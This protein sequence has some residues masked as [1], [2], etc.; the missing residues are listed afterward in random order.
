MD[1]QTEILRINNIVA[2]ARQIIPSEQEPKLL[3]RFYNLDV[4]NRMRIEESA[5]MHMKQSVHIIMQAIKAND[6]QRV[7]VSYSGGKASQL[8]LH[9]ADEATFNTNVE[10]NILYNNTSLDFPDHIKYVR[11]YCNEH[12]PH[13]E[14]HEIH[15]K[16]GESFNTLAPALGFPTKKD[17]WCCS[18]LKIRPT[19]E[20]MESVQ[21]RAIQL[22]GNQKSENSQRYNYLYYAEDH[23]QKSEIPV[24]NPLLNWDD[25]E[26]WSYLHK[27]H[28]DTSPLY[29]KTV[30]W[31][32][33]YRHSHEIQYT[34]T[35]CYLCPLSETHTYP[36]WLIVKMH[37]PKLWAIM[38]KAAK[39][40]E[41]PEIK[42]P[43][44]IISK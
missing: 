33:K 23:P 25:L 28:R 16:K 5:N 42:T 12:F 44:T 15:P 11:G 20:Y 13:A 31:I 37:Y 18:P 38:E 7:F 39:G 41:K 21:G 17:Y 43:K 6:A 19:H 32:D 10:L 35:G 29:N 34:R 40:P 22:L 36:H 9:A 30:Y 26:I 27:Y 24:Y 14:Y 4:F 8:L 2:N 1:I 3:T